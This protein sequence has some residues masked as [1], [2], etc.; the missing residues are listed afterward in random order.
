MQRVVGKKALPVFGFMLL[1]LAGCD[2]FSKKDTASHQS[3]GPAQGAI[4][5]DSSGVLL[6]IDGKPA[7]T[8]AEFEGH[9]D[10]IVE[11]NPQIAAAIQSM[12]AMKYNIFSGMMSQ[13][14]LR[15]WVKKSKVAESKEYQDDLALMH[16]MVEFELARKYFQDDVEKEITVSASD[17]KKYYDDHKA[18]IPDLVI[19]PGGVKAKGIAFKKEHPAEVFARHE[20]L[21]ENFEKIAKA[22]GLEVVD[23][24]LINEYNVDV[25]KKVKEK[26][27]KALKVPSIMR[28]KQDDT[29]Y[30]ICL[31]TE[32]QD[33][34]YRPLAQVQEG[35]EQMLRNEKMQLLFGQKIEA[36]KTVYRA[37][38]D[39][40]YFEKNNMQ[41]LLEQMQQAQMDEEQ[42]AAP[43]QA[44]SRVA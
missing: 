32:K 18:S 14:L 25:D 10:K 42:A 31:V 13:E 2:W 24:G 1:V 33:A 30:W 11:S 29:H 35:I 26:L 36:L 38:E 34:E 3:E 43:A 41:E 6:S 39:R 27:S 4:Q 12:P 40:S 17:I 7:I 22:E 28:V 21:A 20:D 15:A 44:T 16:K 23:F 19:N 8:V 37:Q 5:T 9:L